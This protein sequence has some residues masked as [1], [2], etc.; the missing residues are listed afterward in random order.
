MFP[1]IIGVDEEV[2]AIPEL[3]LLKIVLPVIDGFEEVRPMPFIRLPLT[4]LAVIV[5]EGEF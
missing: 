5:E 4:I 2:D 3:P 1:V